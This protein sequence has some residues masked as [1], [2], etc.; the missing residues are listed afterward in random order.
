L[1]GR[2]PQQLVAAVGGA[3]LTAATLGQSTLV[4]Y[5]FDDGVVDT[6]PDTF[7]V[8]EHAKGRVSLSES[9][10]FSGY[11]AVEIRDVAADGDF[12][13]LQ[14]YFPL[15]ND[16]MLYVHF[17]FLITDPTQPL[18]IALAGPLWFRLAKDGIAFWLTTRQGYIYQYSDSM[19]QRLFAP[20]PFSWY[21]VQ[22]EYDID[23]GRYDLRIF[24]E[25]DTRPVVDLRNQPNAANQPGSAVDKFSFIGD[26]GEDSSNVVYYVDDVVIGVDEEVVQRP[27]AAP[28]RRKLFIDYW[29][30]LQRQM[31]E[32]VACLPATE[33]ADFGLTDDELALIR[34]QGGITVIKRINRDRPPPDLDA[35][36]EPTRTY[37]RAVAR[38]KAGCRA[39]DRGLPAEAATAFEGAV[40]AVPGARIFALSLL[41]AEAAM[42][43]G[44]EVDRRLLGLYPDWQGDP[45]FAV[46]LAM[47]AIRKRDLL[48]AKQW[49]VDAPQLV[50]ASSRQHLLTSFLNVSA[51]ADMFPVLN[52]AT[53]AKTYLAV[54]PYLLAEQYFYL[55][56]WDRRYRDAAVFADEVVDRL[57]TAGLPTAPWQERAGDAYMLGGDQAEATAAYERSL[58]QNANRPG[59]YTKLSDLYYL[60]HDLERERQYREKVFGTLRN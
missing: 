36:P 40:S 57:A 51:Q 8:Y 55:L 17:A 53:T 44:G 32:R 43:P 50:F 56:L 3:L 48:L 34:G 12:P 18:N 49:W 25:H 42:Q 31:R 39:L 23:R 30:D 19:P 45:R 21:R 35:L 60:Q 20:E 37:A 15:R 11:R 24:A 54:E 26:R 7:T 13:E 47:L 28:G 9:L 58:S 16:G 2:I 46:A 14:G 29:A 6:G 41:L 27:F 4:E 1:A 10:R 59:P 38:W 33:I 52:A 22:L 5:S